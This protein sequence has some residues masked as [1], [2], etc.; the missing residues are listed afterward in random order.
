[1][2]YETGNNEPPVWSIVALAVTA[3]FLLIYVGVRI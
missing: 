2:N 1:M 3:V